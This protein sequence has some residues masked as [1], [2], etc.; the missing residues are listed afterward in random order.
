MSSEGP[1]GTDTRRVDPLVGQL[2][3]ERYEIL[4]PLGQGG[5][6]NVYLAK[7]LE[8]RQFV[9]V[10]TPRPDLAGE[11]GRDMKLLER[12]EQEAEAHAQL[13]HP[14][15]VRIR[16]RGHLTNTKL[17]LPFVVVDFK[18]G[19]NLDAR[20]R[21]RGQKL[22]DVLKWLKPIA[23]A[24]DFSHE[25]GWIHRDVKPD[26]ILFDDHGFVSL[27]DFGIAKRMKTE[28]EV[29]ASGQSAAPPPP[30]SVVHSAL[31]ALGYIPPEALS[32]DFTAAYDQY[33]VAV[34]VAQALSG[35]TP[36]RRIGSHV[37]EELIRQA[38]KSASNAIH[39]ALSE[40]PA[41]RFPSC[42]AFAEALAEEASWWRRWRKLA[43]PAVA[44]LGLIA[45]LGWWLT[46]PP[47]P[48]EGDQRPEVEEH[49]GTGP[50]IGE[51]S[52]PPPLRRRFELGST[53]EE[54][55]RATALCEAHLDFSCP[56][57]WFAEGVRS[58]ELEPF[59]L[60]AREVTAGEFAA[61][62]AANPSHR[63]AAEVRG[64]SFVIS[65]LGQNEVAGLTW[66]E[67]GWKWTSNLPVVHVG[68]ADAEAYCGWAGGRL[69]TADEWEALA[70][71]TER[72]I[73]P[74]G[75]NWNPAR[76]RWLGSDVVPQKPAPVADFPEAPAGYFDLAG[77]VWEWTSSKG[78]EAD[79]ALGVLKGGSWAD[80]TPS[81]LR[82]AA[83]FEVEVDYS[84]EDVGF[85]CARTVPAWPDESQ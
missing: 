82:S 30:E 45:A 77:N 54:T 67:P 84:A 62:I 50:I 38:P 25:R 10:K 36:S 57:E 46:S 37:H 11:L 5:M 42:L 72:R 75:N 9:V 32:R 13:E 8:T 24:L 56:A 34:I 71:G 70:R 61:F 49:G 15:I 44:T 23:M 63:T 33:S 27:S 6:A 64:S 35:E 14:H 47:D 31:G 51:V 26:N 83:T 78:S 40:N 7:D 22:D 58:V 73:F 65:V 1:D 74:W 66:H 85:R 48:Q 76:A 16:G 69:P 60:D 68:R 28:Q 17:K 52:P 18:A 81:N 12:F 55:E 80:L 59:A 79:S 2:L 19:G 39:R 43:A 41:E 4:R 29:P 3:K 21:R 20:L 53:L